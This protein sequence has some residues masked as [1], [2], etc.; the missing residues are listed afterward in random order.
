MPNTN[1]EN[2]ISIIDKSPSTQQNSLQ[3]LQALQTQYKSLLERYQT[4]KAQIM[5]TTNSY[6]SSG[7]KNNEKNVFVSWIVANPISKYIGAYG[8]VSDVPA[9]N[10]INKGTGYTYDQCQQEAISKSTTYFGL[11]NLGGIPAS[12]NLAQCSISNDFTKVTQYGTV[13]PKCSAGSDGNMYSSSADTLALYNKNGYIDCYKDD[14]T[15]PALKMSGPDLSSYS[16]VY[17][18]GKIGMSPWNNI[19]NK[20]IFPDL[21]AYWIWYTPN[22]QTTAPNNVGAP[23]TLIYNFVYSGTGYINANLNVCC[24]NYAEMYLNAVKFGTVSTWYT[25][26]EAQFTIEIA[27]GSNYISAA[28][29][30]AGGPAGFILTAIDS[31]GQVLFNTNASW[32]YTTIPAVQLIPSGQNYSVATCSQ[33]ANN[34]N[35]QYFGLKNG[36]DGTS[37]CMVG[38]SYTDATKYGK[39]VETVLGQDNQ[40]YGKQNINAVYE[41]TT[42][43]YPDDLGKLGYINN[44]GTLSQYPSSMIDVSSGLPVI[45]GDSSCPTAKNAVNITSDQWHEYTKSSDMTSTTKCGLSAKIQSDS[46]SSLEIETEMKNVMSQ[47]ITRINYLKQLDSD[48]ISQLG[49]NKNYL[50]SMFDEYTNTISNFDYDQDEQNNNI[51]NIVSDSGIVVTQMNYNYILWCVLAIAIIVLT[52]VI[53]RKIT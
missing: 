5:A 25:T 9:M 1:I 30:N 4:S 26:G 16:P 12:P 11:E 24:D 28:V 47:I 36:T 39:S 45:N 34:G 42:P 10:I 40:I 14:A 18:C 2:T 13:L 23:V 17:V 7:A 22:S 29:E 8:D 51:N 43:G 19:N 20:N 31:T 37:F 49:I 21:T 48:A 44:D 41:V 27:P 35:Y 52:I 15:S 53:I 50:D 38:N 32:K 6:I 3:E 33:Y 46:M